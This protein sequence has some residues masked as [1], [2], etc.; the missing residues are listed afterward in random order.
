MLFINTRRVVSPEMSAY[1]RR[2]TNKYLE[3][4]LEKDLKTN[5]EINGLSVFYY[6][7]PTAYFMGIVSGFLFAI[8]LITK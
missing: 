3:K 4:C 5:S 7:A 8:G 2:S 1:I 6:N